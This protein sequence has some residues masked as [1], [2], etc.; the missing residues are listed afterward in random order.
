MLASVTRELQLKGGDH[1]RKSVD[2]LA[3]KHIASKEDAKKIVDKLRTDLREN[4]LV[5][6]KRG[7][8]VDVAPP[9]APVVDTLTVEPLLEQFIPRHVALS[10]RAR[11]LAN[12]RCCQGA[13]ARTELELPTGERR[14]FG[15]WLVRD[16][17]SDAIDKLKALR[18]QQTTIVP[19]IRN[20]P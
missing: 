13:I 2:K 3:G 16:V 9:T 15:A 5:T 12:A 10:P 14:Y 11:S 17:T 18:T 6:V 8:R 19:K 4:R 7:N 1:L 20:R